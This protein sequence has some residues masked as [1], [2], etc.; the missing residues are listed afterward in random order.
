MAGAASDLIPFRG[1]VRRLSG[2][3]RHDSLVTAAINAG[4]VRRAYL[5]GLGNHGTA[6]CRPGRRTIWWSAKRRCPR[7]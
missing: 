2:A 3:Q 6:S 7:R 1:W 4:A 5:K